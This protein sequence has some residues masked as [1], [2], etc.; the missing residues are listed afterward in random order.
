MNETTL[1]TLRNSLKLIVVVVAF[2]GVAALAYSSR[3]ENLERVEASTINEE[4]IANSP[5]AGA[6]LTMS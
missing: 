1:F 6:P 3:L 5:L 2:F 4:S